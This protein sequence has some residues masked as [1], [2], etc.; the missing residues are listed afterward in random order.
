MVADNNFVNVA[1]GSKVPQFEELSYKKFKKFFISFLMRYNRAHL[2]LTTKKPEHIHDLDP[3]IGPDAVM[4]QILMR[5]VNKEKVRWRK[6][7]EIAYSYLMEV[8]NA[9]PKACTTAALYEGYDAKGLLQALEERFLNVEEN[10]VQAEVTKFISM[11]ITSN[12]TGAEFVDSVEAQAKSSGKSWSGSHRGR[13][14][15]KVGLTDKR[16]SQLAHSLYA[17]HDMTYVR[18]SSLIKVL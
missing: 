16:Y 18:A 9:H 1:A 14:V 11:R 3:S 10:T 7:N 12:Q 13:Q 6:R 2:L 17:A 15:D 4:T 8:C 5:M